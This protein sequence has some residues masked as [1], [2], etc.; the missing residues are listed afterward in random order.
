MKGLIVIASILLTGCA[1]EMTNEQVQVVQRLHT[2]CSIEYTE[3]LGESET[4]TN[5]FCTC[6]LRKSAVYRG[7]DEMGF[8]KAFSILF[9][10]YKIT[11]D[12]ARA[13]RSEDRDRLARF[14]RSQLDKAA[15]DL[16]YCLDEAKETSYE[17]ELKDKVNDKLG[18]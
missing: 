13:I 17:I 11:T 16:D 7:V 15:K 4:I 6:V 3:I 9:K 14:P 8:D 18:V 10:N 1:T 12:L 2:R 5:D